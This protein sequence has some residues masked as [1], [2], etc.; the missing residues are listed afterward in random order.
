MSARDRSHYGFTT[1]DVCFVLPTTERS[2]IAM[3]ENGSFETWNLKSSQVTPSLGCALARATILMRESFFAHTESLEGGK[4]EHVGRAR[5]SI[6][7]FASGL[8]LVS[9]SAP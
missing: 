9:G 1:S 7:R 5:R 6:F 4:C 2:G 8:R 3:L